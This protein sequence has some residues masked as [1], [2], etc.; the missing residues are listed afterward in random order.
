[1]LPFPD[2]IDRPAEGAGPANRTDF[3]PDVCISPADTQ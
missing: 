3:P 1:M 2:G